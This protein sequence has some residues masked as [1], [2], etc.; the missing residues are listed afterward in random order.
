[1]EWNDG[2]NLLKNMKSF[3]RIIRISFIWINSHHP[4]CFLS[5]FS[6]ETEEEELDEDEAEL[7]DE[8]E[9]DELEEEGLWYL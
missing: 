3:S 8:D 9:D 5:L 7:L 4:L 2:F 1:M 6:A